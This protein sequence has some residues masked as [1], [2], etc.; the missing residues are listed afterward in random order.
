MSPRRQLHIHQPGR[1][2]RVSGDEPF[3]S[4]AQSM[5]LSFSPRERG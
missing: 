3:I 5:G 2:P 4:V 1:F